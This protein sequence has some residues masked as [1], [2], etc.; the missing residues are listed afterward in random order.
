MG[1]ASEILNNRFGEGPPKPQPTRR[2]VARHWKAS[3]VIRA[4]VE[5]CGYDIETWPTPDRELVEYVVK[6]CGGWNGPEVKACFATGWNGLAT[7]FEAM[8]R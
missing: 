3:V 6:D 1:L 8:G 4:C 5:E 2:P 7:Y